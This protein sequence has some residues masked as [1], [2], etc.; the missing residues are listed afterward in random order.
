MK[1]NKLFIAYLAGFL[2][3]GLVFS[4]CEKTFKNE[5]PVDKDM[6]D[7]SIVQVYL[8]TLNTNRNF[9]YVDNKPVNGASMVPGTLFPATGY[10]FSVSSGLKAF[11]LR[12]TL[13]AATQPPLAFSQQLDVGKHYTLFVYDTFTTPKQKIVQDNIVV[14]ADTSTRIRFANFI[15]NNTAVPAVDIFSWNRNANLVTNLAVTDVS[16]FIPYPSRLAVDTFYV[17]ETGT[18]NLLLKLTLTGGLTDKR[19]YTFVY[20]GS[21][22]VGKLLNIIPTR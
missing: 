5:L 4:A 3:T 11:L 6:N 2:A 22:K 7:N 16:N 19:S 21:H 17:R 8:T 13:S 15:Y 10:G 1:K 9:L 14:P 12:D 18:S 20:R